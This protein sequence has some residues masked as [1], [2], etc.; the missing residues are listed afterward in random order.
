MANNNGFWKKIG[1][2]SSI[3][4]VLVGVVSGYTEVKIKASQ[5]EKDI[6]EVKMDIKEIKKDQ[7]TLK[8]QNAEILAAVKYLKKKAE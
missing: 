7:I 2:I 5:N 3:I 6:S 4:F 8:V 1:I